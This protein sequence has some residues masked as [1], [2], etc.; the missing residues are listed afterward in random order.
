MAALM[1]QG[2]QQYFTA[3]GIPLVGGKVYTY[4]AGTTTPLATYTTAAASTPNANPVIL[5][6]RGEASIFFSAAN[7]K[8]VVKDSLDSTIWTQDNL[9]G[10]TAASVL[11]S[12]ALS[13]GTTLIGWVRSLTG[14]VATTLAKWLGW[15]PPSVF[16]FMTDAQIADV[17]SAAFTLDCRA[18][19]QQAIDS[20]TNVLVIPAGTYRLT[21]GSAQTDEAGTNYACL[22]MRSNLHIKAEKG[23][24]FKLANNQSSD[25]APLNIPM[26]FSNSVLSNITFD[27]LE[28]DMNGANNGINNVNHTFAHILFSGTPAGVVAG[29]SNVSITN[30]IF[31]NTP[32]ATC[33]GLGQSGALTGTISSNWVIRGNQFVNNGLDCGDHSSIYAIADRVICTDNIFTADTMA[34]ATGGQAAYEV[35][36]ADQ[37]FANN[38][39]GNYYQGLYV[40]TN[41]IS[42]ADN[43]IISDNVLSPVSDYGV[44]FYR[45]SAAE[46]AIN[47]VSIM[48]NIIGLSDRSTAAAF[49]AGVA[50]TSTYPVSNIL[51]EGNQCSKVGTNEAS[52]FVLISLQAVAVGTNHTGIK[53]TGNAAYGLTDGVYM[54]TAV[55]AIGSVSITNNTF[56]NFATAGV[57]TATRGVYL[58]RLSGVSEVEE[59]IISGNNFIQETGA[60]THGIY[61]LSGVVVDLYLGPD[62]SYSG[63]TTNYA[64]GITVTNRRG[65]YPSKAYTPLVNIGGAVTIG[66][67]TLEGSYV[68][69][70]GIVT[71]FVKYVVGST[72]TIPGGNLNIGLP[73]ASINAGQI[74]MGDWRINDASSGFNY[75]G[76][77]MNDGTSQY[78]SFRVS[79][80]TIADSNTPVVLAA[81]DTLNLQMIYKAGTA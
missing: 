62:N 18:A 44:T 78:A 17:Q 69:D 45:E 54:T 40:A 36:G 16:E 3:G 52:A 50:I 81:G 72:D 80:A 2:K 27:G 41:K 67:G 23:A 21:K 37:I 55:N 31:R 61:L 63:C 22:T 64:E 25:A 79:G 47:K 8:I 24:I 6:S 32:G 43:I 51:I 9:A 7:Y 65:Y 58:E 48:N 71:A 26:F 30:C 57:E 4:A 60:M 42:E 28:I 13:T 38:R 49:K 29:A 75:F 33:I 19:I 70:A 73:F 46:T 11:A 12:L 39:V 53:I 68:Y 77:A 14:A 66:D 74:Y 10:D 56:K 1:P 5:D 76:T 59:L 15:Q 20:S 34:D 35:H